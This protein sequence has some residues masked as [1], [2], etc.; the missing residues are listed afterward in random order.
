MILYVIITVELL[1]EYEILFRK[2]FTT[3]LKGTK[4]TIRMWSFKQKDI[5]QLLKDMIYP[6]E[7]W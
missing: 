5:E 4:Q 2:D 6:Y 1:Q 7:G 3:K